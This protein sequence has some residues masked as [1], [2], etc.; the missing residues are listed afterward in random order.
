M[1]EYRIYKLLYLGEAVGWFFREHK[2]SLIIPHFSGHMVK[3]NF[4]LK[5]LP[6]D[7]FTIPWHRIVTVEEKGREI[8]FTCNPLRP[9]STLH[10]KYYQVCV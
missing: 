2:G 1:S 7:Y 8:V 3:N 6:V 9:L 10:F 5:F 4:F